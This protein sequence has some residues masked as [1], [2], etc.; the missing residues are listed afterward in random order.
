MEDSTAMWLYF[1][2]HGESEANLLQEFSNS[3]L[4]HPL[5]ER[6]LAQA[7]R[8]ADILA[9]MPVERVYSSPV[10][11]AQQTARIIAESLAAPLEI[12]EALREWDVGIYEGTRDPECWKLHRQVQEDWFY[13][14]RLGSKM[15]GG[16]SFLEIQARF[17]PFI[18]GLL[19]SENAGSRQFVLVGHGGLYLAMLPVVLKNI[20]I[21]FALQHGVDYTGCVI[22]EARPDGLSCL[23]WGGTA[24]ED[25]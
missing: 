13:H 4:K 11:R 17:V 5:T 2:R 10:L 16:E 7:Q 25:A 21:A 12:T 20:D 23:S 18:Q 14:G 9:G 3:G 6:G 22:A 24:V 8:V 19:R 1:V 15:P